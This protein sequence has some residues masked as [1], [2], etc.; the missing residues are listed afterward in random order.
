M[1]LLHDNQEEKILKHNAVKDGSVD[2]KY[3]LNIYGFRERKEDMLQNTSRMFE[4]MVINPVK[5][6]LSETTMRIT[7]VTQTW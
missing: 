5:E 1:K 6:G 4:N 7:N 2:Y 3:F